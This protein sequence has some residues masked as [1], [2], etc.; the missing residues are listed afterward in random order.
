MSVEDQP[1]DPVDPEVDDVVEEV[2]LSPSS[3]T[4]VAVIAPPDPVEPAM[5]TESPGCTELAEADSALVRVVVSS[6]F[7]ATV[8]PEL[9]LT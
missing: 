9:S 4:E 8:S 2:E 5:T 1:V 3:V 6:S 7:T